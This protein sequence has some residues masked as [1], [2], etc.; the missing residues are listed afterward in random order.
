MTLTLG[1]KIAM[2]SVTLGV[3]AGATAQLTPL[4]GPGVATDIASLA[5]LLNTV[6]SGWIFIVTG[7]SNTVQQVAAMPGV[8]RISVNANANP[9][10][11]AVATDPA[12]Q[13]VGPTTPDV[14]STLVNIAKAS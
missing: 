5:S 3:L 13:K 8:E 9:T 11:A 1:Q 7:Q 14:R 2:G 12:Q 6:L 4:V 10:L